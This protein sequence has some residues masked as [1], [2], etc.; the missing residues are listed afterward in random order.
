MW[1]RWA[2][3][4]TRLYWA[5]TG[6]GGVDAAEGLAA[7]LVDRPVH[8]AWKV[9]GPRCRP[10]LAINVPG[11]RDQDDQY[12]GQS[13]ALLCQGMQAGDGRQGKKGRCGGQVLVAD[14][15]LV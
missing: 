14:L 1:V 10:Y 8:W 9:F 5:L 4:G 2:R 11:H 12:D 7:R 15:H 13:G 3:W 6:R